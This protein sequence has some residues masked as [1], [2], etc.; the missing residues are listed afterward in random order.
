VRCWYGVGDV[1]PSDSLPKMPRLLLALRLAP[2]G[3]RERDHE[4]RPVE[5]QINS[6][7]DS[8]GHRGSWSASIDGR[9]ASPSVRWPFVAEGHAP[10]TE[11][12]MQH[13]GFA[14][15]AVSRSCRR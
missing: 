1:I 13:K 5:D 3:R 15:V 6:L 8:M 2:H 14:I 7:I 11:I 4:N 10:E 9:I 12:A